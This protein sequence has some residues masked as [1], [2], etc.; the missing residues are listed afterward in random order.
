M[1]S[2]SDRPFFLPA[3]TPAEAI[4]RIYSLTGAQARG[5]RGEKGAVLALRD[6]LGLDLDIARTNAIMAARIAEALGVEWRSS[7]Y[8][9]LN[10]VTLDGLNALLEG[11]TDA[12]H[13]GSLR[14]LARQRPP[15]LS[16]PPWEGFRPAQSK[17][18]AVNR[19]SAL[20][21]SGPE[22]LG[23]GSKERKRVLVN[24]ATHLE[25]GLST[26]L[27]KTRLSEALARRFD[28]PWTD[29][30]ESTGETISLIGLNTLLAGAERRLGLL[31]VELPTIFGTPEDEGS[32]LAAAL[33][34]GWRPERQPDG[35]RRVHWDGRASIQWMVDQGLTRGP[36]DN[37]WQGFYFEAR[38]RE[39]LS[40]AFAPNPDPP[41][42]TYENTPFDYSLHYVWDLKAH[43]E[44]WLLP[45]TAARRTGQSSAP[46]NDQAAM[47]ACIADQGLGFLMLSGEGVAD[48][49]GSFVAWHREFKRARN[50]KS[51]P[52]NSGQSRMRKAAFE[53][54]H[55]EAFWFPNLLALEA[56]KISG[57]L[58]GFQEDFAQAPDEVGG[59]GRPRRPKY[60][61]NAR[62]AR[63]S[64][65][66][67]ARSDFPCEADAG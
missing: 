48:E 59:R 4:A 45:L 14:R 33:V 9:D 37:E 34:D 35:G 19:I 36:N 13:D 24:L 12:F 11:A 30:C 15:G 42:S 49:D 56:A 40:A 31:G 27:S 16:A 8:T 22:D 1:S 61:L 66:L 5:T 6:A 25:P 29:E 46:L 51:K 23:P 26:R 41:R 55:V 54:L 58:T 10:K 2:W 20:T 38:G 3:T 32:A 52:S 39:I 65:A 47:D 50:V 63:D 21:G 44:S 60:S 57:M 7:A 67:V 64:T 18:E 43:T 53:P 28:A 62:K 17:I